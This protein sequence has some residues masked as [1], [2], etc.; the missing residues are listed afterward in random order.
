MVKNKAMD[1]SYL[2]DDFETMTSYPIKNFL[3]IFKDFIDFQ[4]Q[5]VLSWYSGS[6]EVPNIDSFNRLNWLLLESRN[7]N[8][9]FFVNRDRFITADWWELGEII[10]DICIK[11]ETISNS[12]K[13]YRSSIT[14]NKFTNKIE[15]SQ[16]L[17]QKQTLEQLSDYVGYEDK[18]ND[19]VDVAIRNDLI[20]EDYTSEGGNLINIAY[21]STSQVN[22]FDVFDNLSNENLYGKDVYRIITFENNDLKVLNYKDTMLQ[23]CGILIN[24]KKNSNPEFPTN[25]ID[26]DIVAGSNRSNIQYPVLMR[27]L[28]NTFS[29][30]DTISSIE[31]KKFER[32]QDSILI[33][34]DI[35][36]KL[37]EIIEQKALL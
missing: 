36:T 19:W 12:S 20:E 15:V 28:Y 4:E 6:T 18:D 30:D 17:R 5:D 31:I 9:V 14:K 27:Q 13:Y 32:V 23:A 22:I 35:L 1:L 37:N 33:E 11:L 16:I 8:N 3:G 24:L 29:N 34:I 26:S 2:I 7:L 10:E 25:G 21:Q